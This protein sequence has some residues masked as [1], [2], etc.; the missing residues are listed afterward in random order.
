LILGVAIG[1]GVYAQDELGAVGA[2]QLMGHRGKVTDEWIDVIRGVWGEPK[3]SYQG[4]FITVK[5]AEVFPK[6]LQQPAPTILVG[7]FKEIAHRR[8]ALRGDGWL[9]ISAIPSDLVR[10]REYMRKVADEAGRDPDK[11]QIG[12]EHWL[13]IDEDK[14]K[15]EARPAKTMAGLSGYLRSR[16]DRDSDRVGQVPERH[17]FGDPDTI[18]KKI[19]LYKEA[20]V[21]HLIVRPIAHEFPQIL[22]AL[23]LFKRRVM[24]RLRD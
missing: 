22:D 14:T 8:A 18:L 12:S 11:I 13:S 7:G 9:A 2:L 19:L 4:Q 3:F 24:D 20:G 10:A 21:D 1:G 6:P 5:D 15:A 17:F 23:H 16:Q